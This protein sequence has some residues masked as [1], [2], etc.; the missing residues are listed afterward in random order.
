MSRVR[1]KENG[2]RSIFHL[3]FEPISHFM[4]TQIP[5]PKT[6]VFRSNKGTVI[7]R[8][9]DRADYVPLEICEVFSVGL[10]VKLCKKLSA[11]AVPDRDSA[12][13]SGRDPFAVV[14]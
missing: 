14:G 6:L 12:L 11:F 3:V 9:G 2:S 7:M 10:V 13:A 4:G 8:E 5:A 1:G